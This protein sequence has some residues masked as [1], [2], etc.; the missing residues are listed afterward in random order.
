M[1]LQPLDLLHKVY[2]FNYLLETLMIWPLVCRVKRK[3][4]NK[5]L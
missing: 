4:L 5:Q 3:F 1:Y 2:I